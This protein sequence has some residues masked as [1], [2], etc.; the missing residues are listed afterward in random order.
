MP[1]RPRVALPCPEMASIREDIDALDSQIVALL[2]QRQQLVHQAGLVK[3]SRD[4]IIDHDRIEEVVAHV[5]ELAE[6]HG[7][8]RNIAEPLWRR[9]I[10]LS[11]DY[12]F[13]VYDAR[14]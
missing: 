13:K 3:P 10:E 2:A 5:I 1:N 14:P 11:I 9:L 6:K 12:E 4:D 8:S 7:L